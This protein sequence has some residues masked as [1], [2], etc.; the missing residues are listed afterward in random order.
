MTT[1]LLSPSTVVRLALEE[2]KYKIHHDHHH[3]QHIGQISLRKN[4]D[5]KM[6]TQNMKQIQNKFREDKIKYLG[7][8]TIPLIGFLTKNLA[9][10]ERQ[11]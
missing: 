2:R 10:L 1:R 11:R 5:G 9:C 7:M 4:I 6:K 3:H 8:M